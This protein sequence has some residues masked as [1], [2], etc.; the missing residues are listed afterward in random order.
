MVLAVIGGLTFV[1]IGSLGDHAS[2]DLS[3]T[4]ENVADPASLVRRF[5]GSTCPDNGDNDHDGAGDCGDN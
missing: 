5:D 2:S 3:V 4:A 1:S